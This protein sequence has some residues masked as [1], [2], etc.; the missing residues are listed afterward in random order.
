MKYKL[1]YKDVVVDVLDTIKYVRY[2]QK[3]NKIVTTDR[4]S[5]HGVFGSNGKTVYILEGK[6]YPKN[7]NYKVVKLVTITDRE[8]NELF[9]TLTTSERVA[10]KV[11]IDAHKK[12]KL[13]E[14]SLKCKETIINGI[15][16]K[17]SDGNYHSFRLTTEDQL[18]LLTIETQLQLKAQSTIYHETGK[19][20]EVYSVEDMLTIISY[21]RKHIDYHTTYYNLLKYCVNN[22]TDVEEIDAVEYGDDLTKYSLPQSLQELLSEVSK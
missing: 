21:A 18:N 16:V 11:V 10:K 3:F 2:I 17:L 5:A 13:E 9:N 12:S 19:P 6:P 4:T 22:L 14:L 15:I 1:I 7:K 20:C 8:Y